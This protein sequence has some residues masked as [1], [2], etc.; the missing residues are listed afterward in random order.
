MKIK[1]SIVSQLLNIFLI[2]LT[3]LILILMNLN[4][5]VNLLTFSFLSLLYFLLIAIVLILLNEIIIRRLYVYEI[6]EKGIR[7]SFSLFSKREVFIPY[8]NITKLELKK[9]FVGRLLNYGD[10]EVVS[11]SSNKIILKGIK[12]PETILKKIKSRFEKYEE[13]KEENE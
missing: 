13:T 4:Y 6:E 5:H 8:S 7:E 11:S 9:S 10:I 12:N 3:F 1:S 2:I